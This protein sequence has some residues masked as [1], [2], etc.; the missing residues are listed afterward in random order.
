MDENVWPDPFTE[1]VDEYVRLH[2]YF[3]KVSPYTE[4]MHTR[5]LNNQ[6][7]LRYWITCRQSQIPACA[8]CW[9]VADWCID[10]VLILCGRRWRRCDQCKY[11][12]IES[13]VTLDWRGLW[14][15]N[16]STW[17]RRLGW[18]L[19]PCGSKGW[20]G[21]WW[22]RGRVN[23]SASYLFALWPLFV[24]IKGCV[25]L[26]RWPHSW[27]S[28]N[29]VSFLFCIWFSYWETTAPSQMLSPL[30]TASVNKR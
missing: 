10:F 8:G 25:C 11:R 18:R 3:E 26:M 7:M 14:C 13:R 20:L 6:L 5:Y 1:K 16:T 23:S 29:N 2:T 30:F 9:T 17:H 4:S 28:Q 24:W 12:E 19:F 21:S 15:L 27:K 22:C